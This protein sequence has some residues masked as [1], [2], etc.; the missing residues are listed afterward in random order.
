MQ[1]LTPSQ[2]ED[3]SGGIAFLA[4][5]PF[6]FAGI[7]LAAGATIGVVSTAIYFLSKD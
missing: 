2:L 6:V 4:A 7:G 5:A 1:A 3:V